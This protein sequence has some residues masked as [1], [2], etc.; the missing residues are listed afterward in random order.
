LTI[1]KQTPHDVC[2]WLLSRLCVL[3][4]LNVAGSFATAVSPSNK[5]AAVLKHRPSPLLMQRQLESLGIHTVV[6]NP[7]GH[8]V[9]VNKSE[10]C[11]TS[12]DGNAGLQGL[13]KTNAAQLKDKRATLTREKLD[14]TLAPVAQ[15][16]IA[17]PTWRC[18]GRQCLPPNADYKRYRAAGGAYCLDASAPLCQRDDAGWCKKSCQCPGNCA[19]ACGRCPPPVMPTPSPTPGVAYSASS[20]TS[21]GLWLFMLASSLYYA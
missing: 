18:I 15:C 11:L 8:V 7:A 12:N 3:F 10:P 4:W 9:S 1:M 17:N 5:D 16:L 2:Q 21:F 14:A 6:V 20:L 19:H 13:D